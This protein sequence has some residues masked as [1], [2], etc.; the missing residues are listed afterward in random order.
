MHKDSAM[1]STSGVQ[2]SQNPGEFL[3]WEM[4]G[5]FISCPDAGIDKLCYPNILLFTYIKKSLPGPNS[6]VP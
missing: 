2:I 4:M 1:G 5:L 6:V 3:G